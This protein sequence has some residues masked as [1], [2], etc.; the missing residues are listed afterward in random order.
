LKTATNECET[1]F[2]TLHIHKKSGNSKNDSPGGASPR[3]GRAGDEWNEFGRENKEKRLKKGFA[4][5]TIHAASAQG[6]T[7]GEYAAGGAS[8]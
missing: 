1:G 2:S 3:A 6:P 5:T 4:T 7:S 8:E